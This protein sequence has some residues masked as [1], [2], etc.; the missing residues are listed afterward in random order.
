MKF[1]RSK[2]VI[3]PRLQLWLLLG[4]ASLLSLW[5]I[6][7]TITSTP[8]SPTRLVAEPSIPGEEQASSSIGNPSAV[9]CE[10][11]GYTYYIVQDPRGQYGVCRLPGGLVCDAWEFLQGECGQAYNYCGQQ[12]YTTLVKDDGGDAYTRQYGVCLSASGVE[13]GLVTELSGLGKKIT[14]AGC[15]ESNAPLPDL[16]ATPAPAEQPASL[17]VIP[18]DLP[19]SF[20]WRNYLGENWLT[21]V[22]DQASCGSCWA[23][24]AVGA[25]EA[26]HNIGYNNPDLDLNLAEQYLVADCLV[27]HTCC[28]GSKYAA[29]Q[30]IRDQ[31][32]PD[33]ACM[34][35]ADSDCSCPDG[36]C[37]SRR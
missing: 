4:F 36:T 37:S 33:E 14:Q 8:A 27:G 6:I 16:Q 9:Y 10:D 18:D 5:A 13:I 29:L 30:F 35:Y 28:G 1:L 15:N 31:G 21:A 26:A 34:P 23:F 22:K 7:H 24:A 32:I 25:A 12:G 11:L 3:Q 17:P 19:T 20:D 2:P